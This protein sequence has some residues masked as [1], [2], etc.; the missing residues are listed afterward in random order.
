ARRGYKKHGDSPESLRNGE[1]NGMFARIWGDRVRLRLC[2]LVGLDRRDETITPLGDGFDKARFIRRIPQA[3]PQPRYGAIQAVIEI[4]IGVSRPQFLAEL[5]ASYDL[6]R[7]LQQAK[8]NTAGL[9][10]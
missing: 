8:Q 10:L 6:S 2:G 1:F 5:L 3:L 9:I 4:D 7:A